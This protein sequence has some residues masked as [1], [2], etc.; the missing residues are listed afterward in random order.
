M[1]KTS[2]RR[3]VHRILQRRFENMRFCCCED[4][5][6][7]SKN[8]QCESR[9]RMK[10]LKLVVITLTLGI[11]RVTASEI[12]VPVREFVQRNCIECHDRSTAEGDFQIDGLATDLRDSANHKGWTRV[13]ARVQRARRRRVKRMP[14]TPTGG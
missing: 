4:T 11:L 5:I 7:L 3:W 10:I 1:A 2:D 12:P 9:S 8:E 6:I 13:L 14:C